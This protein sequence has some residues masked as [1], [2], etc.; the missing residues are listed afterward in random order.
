MRHYGHPILRTTQNVL[1]GLNMREF[2]TE[3]LVDVGGKIAQTADYLPYDSPVRTLIVYRP[4]SCASA[5]AN[6]RT[7]VLKQFR[8]QYWEE[9]FETFRAEKEV[10][11]QYTNMAG[12][13]ITIKVIDAAVDADTDPIDGAGVLLSDVLYYP[14]ILEYASACAKK[15]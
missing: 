1:N 5:T 6:D 3:I 9:Y 14:G 15:H 2:D 11:F 8:D 10:T 13:V 7:S 4:F 12:N